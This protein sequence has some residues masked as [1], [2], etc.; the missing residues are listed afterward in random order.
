MACGQYTIGVIKFV[1]S[2]VGQDAMYLARWDVHSN[3]SNP[4]K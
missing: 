3:Y 1:H 4:M 2:I